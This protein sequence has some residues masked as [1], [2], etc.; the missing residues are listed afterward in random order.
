MSIRTIRRRGTIIAY[1]ALVGNG[2]AGRT[3][4]F[5]VHTHGDST[6][7]MAQQAELKLKA[8]A[9]RVQR[10]AVGSNAG[11]IPGLQFVYTPSKRDG[12]PPI[13]YA[14]ATWS[15]NGRNIKRC[16]SAQKHGK[17]DAVALALAARERGAGVAVG[18]TVAEALAVM[19][20]R[21]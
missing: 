12:D 8:T 19:E 20:S 16:Y 15:K 17:A 14:K 9:P 5:G 6:L 3:A 4:Y 11:G 21:L 10:P 7:A 18:L 13:L 2:S 1:Q